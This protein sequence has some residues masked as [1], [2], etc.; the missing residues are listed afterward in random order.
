MDKKTEKD[1][2]DAGEHTAHG[3]EDVAEVLADG[4]GGTVK[5]LADGVETASAETKVR[6]SDDG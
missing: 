3:I 5:G 6:A 2:K 1:L 4:V